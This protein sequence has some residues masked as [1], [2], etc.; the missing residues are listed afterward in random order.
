MFLTS[1]QGRRTAPRHAR[2]SARRPE[3]ESL[4]G[5]LVPS[6]ADGTIVLVNLPGPANSP[7]GVIGINPSTGAQTVISKDQQFSVPVDPREAHDGQLY[8]TDYSAYGTGAVFQVDPNTGHQTLVAKGGYINGPV[9]LAVINHKLYISDVGPDDGTFSNIVEINPSN[10]KQRLIASG[11]PFYNPLAIVAAP[12][13]NLYVLDQHA[14]GTGAVFEVS[15]AQGQQ[16]VLSTGGVMRFPIDMGQDANGKLIVFNRDSATDFTMGAGS[17]LRVNPQTG[18][19]TVISSGG[20]LSALDGGAVAPDGTIYVGTTITDPATVPARV[21]AVNPVTGAQRIVTQGQN[22]EI[23]EGMMVYSTKGGDDGG[24]G[25]AMPN[26]PPAT[27]LIVSS[28]QGLTTGLAPENPAT[29]SKLIAGRAYAEPVQ[30]ASESLSFRA[31][32]QDTGWPRGPVW[33]HRMT[34][35]TAAIDS[36]FA[37]WSDRV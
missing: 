26:V 34:G 29:S 31:T 17:V 30:V 25:A 9:A 21:I 33:T 15:I 23:I 1:L 24:G 3:L 35:P 37:E 11:G 36:V 13:N 4:E 7:S 8:V 16:R 28:T 6:I 2:R 32:A 14:L 27:V 18:A 12:G 10:G 5:R 22:L 20:L 19:Q